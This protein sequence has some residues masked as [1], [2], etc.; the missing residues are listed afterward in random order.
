MTAEIINVG[1]EVT[2]GAVVNTDAAYIAARLFELGVDCYAQTTV[3]DDPKRLSLTLLLAL[4]RSDAVILSGGLGPTDDDLTKETVAKT[5]D[6]DLLEDQKALDH[7]KNYFA[8][9][10]D[11]LP[12]KAKKQAMVIKGAKV[13]YNQNGTAPGCIV[14][15]DDK[16]VI[17][18]PGPYNELTEMFEKY[19]YGYLKEKAKGHTESLSLN[20]SGVGESNIEARLKG[21]TGLENPVI[22]TYI[23]GGEV[24]IKITAK[25][26]SKKQAQDTV[27]V[28]ADR[29]KGYFGKHVYGENY[30]SVEYYLVEKL[31]QKGLSIST[32]ESCTAGLVSNKITAVPGASSVFEMGVVAYS[33]EIKINA[34]GVDP[35]TIKTY[36][37]ISEQTAAQMAQNVINLTKSSIGVSVTG[38]AGPGASE[39]KPVGLVYIGI[40]DGKKTAVRKLE[41]S[42]NRERIRMFCAAYALDLARRYLDGDQN[43]LS[44]MTPVREEVVPFSS[45][46]LPDVCEFLDLMPLCTKKSEGK[47]VAVKK[48]IEKTEEQD[49]E[50]IFSVGKMRFEALISKMREFMDAP[51][52]TEFEPTQFLSE[53]EFADAFGDS[54]HKPFDIKEFWQNLKTANARRKVLRGQKKAERKRQKEERKNAPKQ[55]K[56]FI[57]TVF[58]CKGDPFGVLLLKTV[59]V[60]LAAAILFCGAAVGKYYFDNARERE[61]ITLCA[62]NFKT[63]Q[64]LTAGSGGVLNGFT[65]LLSKN[66]QCKGWLAL[67]GADISTPVY[68]TG[69]NLFYQN[70]GTD[71]RFL[72]Q[73]TPF[74]DYACVLGKDDRSQNITVYGTKQNGFNNLDKYRELDFYKQNATFW[75]AD[76]YGVKSY[77]IFAVSLVNTNPICGEVFDYRYSTF[78]GNNALIEYTDL[79]KARSI[80]N[81]GVDI[82]YDDNIITLSVAADDFS[83]A[84]LLV[85]ARE[86]REDHEQ[87][88]DTTAAD[89]NDKCIYPA[90][91]SGK[92][93]TAQNTKTD[94]VGSLNTGD[95]ESKEPINTSSAPLN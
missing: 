33:D 8:K 44:R 90:A 56:G 47:K 92:K 1:N 12:E 35:Q 31:K 40:S 10:G 48:N 54:E 41:L 75:F 24:E 85:A 95:T 81:T 94:A 42:G 20:I 69:D 77:K 9:K 5:L 6:L 46:D 87:N 59:C 18:L 30:G 60:V 58:W 80:I 50:N 73:G 4:S 84:R 64:A 38:N 63:A 23:H 62:Q 76:L 2:S 83:G 89:Y 51:E 39:N 14:E 70:H 26:G 86:V 13:L 57:K 25:G 19:V 17:I 3:D 74:I 34:L 52:K 66:N 27:R 11:A 82:N 43:L 45:Y 67:E 93:P 88:I 91:Y 7:L 37:A 28:F 22:A 36:G 79:L 53:Q 21:L 68:Q 29:L 49:D 15:K 55:K 72:A 32:A 71:G 78:E 61:F 16:T 65:K